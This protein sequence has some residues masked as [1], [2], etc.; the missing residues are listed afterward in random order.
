MAEPLSN[1]RALFQ[2]IRDQPVPVAFL[3]AIPD[4]AAAHYPYFEEEWLDFKSCPRDRNAPKAI[5]EK[6]AGKS[7]AR[8]FRAT[9]TSPTG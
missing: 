5:D 8:R 4:P 9:P 1:A 6:S 7:G 3:T 2:H